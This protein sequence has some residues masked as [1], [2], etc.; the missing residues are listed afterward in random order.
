MANE[1]M[2]KKYV[3]KKGDTLSGISKKHYNTPN[4]WPKIAK[5]NEIQNPDRIRVGQC[6]KI[7]MICKENNKN[8]EQLFSKSELR[9]MIPYATSENIEKFYTPLHDA[10]VKAKINTKNRIAHFLAQIIHE[11]G[12]LKYKEEIASGEA[13]ENRKD[14]GN[15]KK[16]DGKKFKGRGLIQLTGRSNYQ[17]F[18]KSLNLGNKLLENPSLV[19]DTEYSIQAACWFWS[20]H[21]LNELADED[22]IEAITKKINGGTNG[23]TDRK[24][25]LKHIQKISNMRT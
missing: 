9:K 18:G 11:S 23:L 16:G 5:F 10:M 3:V 24:K 17:Q 7:P 21:K 8:T 15:I 12:S 20:K 2:T 22:N 25:H 19:S 13:Y 4:F 6:I 1:S 14:L